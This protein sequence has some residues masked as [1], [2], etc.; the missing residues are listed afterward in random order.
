MHPPVVE[1]WTK[2]SFWGLQGKEWCSGNSYLQERTNFPIRLPS[3][4][5]RLQKQTLL[6]EVTC[7][8]P[9]T[10]DLSRQTVPLSRMT[11]PSGGPTDQATWALPHP[12]PQPPGL[13]AQAS[14][15]PHSEGS[16][17]DH[18]AIPREAVKAEGNMLFEDQHTTIF[19][20]FCSPF[21]VA[22]MEYS[23]SM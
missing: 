17:K 16:W 15:D 21:G 22:I 4:P 1:L 5:Q 8:S 19:D 12:A 3:W 9:H 6:T 18:G 2:E 14:S 10:C 23:L 13:T 11:F 7:V 20:G